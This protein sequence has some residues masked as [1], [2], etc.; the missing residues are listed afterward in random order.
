MI[1]ELIK[2]V[3]MAKG[4]VNIVEKSDVI[5]GRYLAD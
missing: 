1:Y 5:Y 4:E 2:N 3:H